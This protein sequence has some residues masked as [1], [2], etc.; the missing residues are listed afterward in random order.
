MNQQH[1]EGFVAPDL[2][3]KAELDEYL[4]SGMK[5][6]SYPFDSVRPG[7]NTWISVA[8]LEKGWDKPRHKH[9]F[10]QFRYIVSGSVRLGDH[11]LRAGDCA[12]FPESV[13]Y[14]PQH[15][16]EDADVLAVQFPGASG[17]YYLSWDEQAR[18]V[19]RLDA[20]TENFG[21]DVHG[22]PMET[23]HLVWAAHQ[24]RKVEYASP[25]YRDIV[26]MRPQAFDWVPAGSGLERRY[27]GIFGERRTSVEM[28]RITSPQT[29]Q[30]IS[31]HQPEFWFLTGGS[32]TCDSTTFGVG[33]GAMV[34][35]GETHLPSVAPVGSA[36]FLVVRYPLPL[37]I[38]AAPIP[39]E[40]A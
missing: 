8:T 27:L 17:Q 22:R 24:G 32:F 39:E 9:N 6:F 21:L 40:Q 1:V 4:G 31:E 34:R 25:R 14:G 35:T 16:D 23:S 7:E 30:P 2:L 5:V 19:A 36:E 28:V 29:L 13:A 33:A 20:E 38:A 3:V 37:P 10:D 26:M 12:Y 11:V 15:Q 18:V